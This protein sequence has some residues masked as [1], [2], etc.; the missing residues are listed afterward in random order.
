MWK[1]RRDP[2]AGIAARAET[3][4]RTEMNR[5][6][7]LSHH[8]QQQEMANQVPELRKRWIATADARTRPSHLAA[9]WRYKDEPIP[10]SEPFK[11]GGA[12]LMYPGDPAGPP[13]ETVNCRCRSIT[14]H[15][16]VGDVEMGQDQ[17]IGQMLGKGGER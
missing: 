17:A 6:Y 4:V 7:N 8:S 16:L 2:A 10:V 3:I 13:N 14:I 11:V 9:H 15:P 5:V 1:K 12:R